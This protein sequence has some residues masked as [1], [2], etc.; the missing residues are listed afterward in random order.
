ML[1][2]VALLVAAWAQS[3]VTQDIPTQS[4]VGDQCYSH[5]EFNEAGTV[6]TTCDDGSYCCGSRANDCCDAGRGYQINPN[7]GQIV[8]K[9]ATQSTTSTSSSSTSSTSAPATTSS[10]ATAATAGAAQ[11]GSNGA[12]PSQ[13]PPSSGLSGG[14]KAGIAIGAVAGVAIIAGL[15]FLLFRERRKRKALAEREKQ[16]LGYDN[17]Y[18]YGNVGSSNMHQQQQQPMAPPTELG[19]Y[20]GNERKYHYHSELGDGQGRPSELHP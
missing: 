2:P 4:T 10:T 15:A 7:N 19:A 3:A 8:I 13:I 1:L 5:D 17:G 16:P 12:L 14:A 18:G 9:S 11:T 6:L 20:E